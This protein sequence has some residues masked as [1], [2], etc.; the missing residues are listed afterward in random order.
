MQLHA[1]RYTNGGFIL[2]SNTGIL[3]RW[4]ALLH[5]DVPPTEGAHAG[6]FIRRCVCGDCVTPQPCHLHTMMTDGL[7]V[8]C[9]V[10]VFGCAR[11]G[12]WSVWVRPM[13]CA[14]SLW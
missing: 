13:D 4:G 8:P 5:L 10:D 2:P 11:C 3:D 14:T 7:T 6:E 12:R 1:D 9:L